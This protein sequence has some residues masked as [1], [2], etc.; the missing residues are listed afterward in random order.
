[1]QSRISGPRVMSKLPPLCSCSSSANVTRSRIDWGICSQVPAGAALKRD[2]R[3]WGRQVEA[4][5]SNSSSI[6]STC[7][8][9]S[10]A[11]RLS[12][13]ATHLIAWVLPMVLPYIST[14]DSLELKQPIRAA[15]RA[16]T[17]MGWMR[18]RNM[19]AAEVIEQDVLRLHTQVLKH[20]DDRG[21][22]HRRSTHVVL[23]ILRSRMILEVVLVEHVMDE[24]GRAGPVVLRQRIGQCQMPLEVLMLGGQFVVLLD[25]EG[26]AQ[27]ACAVPEGDLALGLDAQQLIH[28]V[29]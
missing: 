4:A 14:T 19:S 16:A 5:S 17:L 26:L 10:E 20:L 2:N 9:T 24:A 12:A 25:V 28:D 7:S 6:S 3:E 15:A 11:G 1:P 23:A 8:L 22:H 29:R 27:R 18:R 21:V 13:S